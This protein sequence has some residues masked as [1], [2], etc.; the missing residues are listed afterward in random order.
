MKRILVFGLVGAVVLGGLI[1]GTATLVRSADVANVAERPPL[2]K[3]IVGNF[4]R[5]ALLR[6]D[7]NLTEEQRA[8][9]KKIAQE[10]RPEIA[11][12]AKKV[13]AAKRGLVEE[14]LAEQPDEQKIRAAASKLSEAI[15][16]AAVFA[17][18]VVPEG[19]KVLTPEQR[20][21]IKAT[22]A[23]CL[24]AEESYLKEIAPAQ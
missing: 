7:L 24:K 16:D 21:K 11:A 8:E 23:D 17:S 19:R 12:V 13:I 6:M 14:V 20:E 18:K 5:F 10:H 3:L 2:A 1:A 15:G 4:M 9:M 22:R